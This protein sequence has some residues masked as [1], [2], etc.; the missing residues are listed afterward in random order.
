M[1]RLND[2]NKELKN[3]KDD[4]KKLLKK[5]RKKKDKRKTM[6]EITEGIPI[7]GK[8]RMMKGQTEN[9]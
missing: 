5:I 9:I 3:K 8:K 1:E 2:L 6:K 7:A 4:E